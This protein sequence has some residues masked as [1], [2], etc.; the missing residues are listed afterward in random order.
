M[1]KKNIPLRGDK[2]VQIGMPVEMVTHKIR[3][4]MDERG[5]NVYGY[6]FRPVMQA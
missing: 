6:K 2:E 1:V 4:D 5:I 3:T